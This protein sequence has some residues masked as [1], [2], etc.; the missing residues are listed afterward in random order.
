MREE[1]LVVEDKCYFRCIASFS[2]RGKAG[3]GEAAFCSFFFLDLDGF[4]QN[5]VL[6]PLLSF[7]FCA[8]ISSML[9]LFLGIVVHSQEL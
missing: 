2:K 4:A 5:R 1:Y 8:R 6:P 7:L 3:G 9:Q